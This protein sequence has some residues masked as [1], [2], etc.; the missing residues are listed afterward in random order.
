MEKGFADEF[1]V[2]GIV[3]D[4]RNGALLAGKFVVMKLIV[5]GVEQM[6]LGIDAM[7]SSDLFL[8][9]NEGIPFLG[10]AGNGDAADYFPA[11]T[12]IQLPQPIVSLFAAP[13][14]LP[15]NR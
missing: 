14:L 12:F 15:R 8:E 13:H 10:I 9:R 11:K 6:N 7:E 3:I 1:F 4:Q 5:F 2:S